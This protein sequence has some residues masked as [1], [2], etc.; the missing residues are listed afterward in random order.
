M[1]IDSALDTLK[2]ILD[3]FEVFR[4]NNLGSLRKKVTASVDKKLQKTHSY[5]K[6]KSVNLISPN[7]C[8]PNWP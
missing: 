3:T 7:K 5:R 4:I 8:S 6:P 2:E 1:C